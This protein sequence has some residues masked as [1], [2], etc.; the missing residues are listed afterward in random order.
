MLLPSILGTRINCIWA[1]ECN[2]PG[3][4]YRLLRQE[5][6]TDL[7]LIG[8]I[9]TNVL[10]MDKGRI[11]EE[12][13]KKVPVLVE[14][15]GYLPLLDGRIREVIPFDNYVYYRNLIEEIVI[16]SDLGEP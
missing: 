13:E 12:V 10:R 11:R 15:G 5:F 9:D 2:D 4:D 6:G 1:C 8:G 16:G 3:L 14:Q 7:R